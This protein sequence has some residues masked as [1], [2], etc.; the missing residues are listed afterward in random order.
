MGIVF[1][2]N[3]GTTITGWLVA[4]VGFKLKLG[5]ILLPFTGQFARFVKSFCRKRN[6]YTPLL[7]MRPC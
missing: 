7:M 6:R 4:V 2:T 3:I 1:G 5:T